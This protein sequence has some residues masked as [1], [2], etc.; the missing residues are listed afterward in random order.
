MYDNIIII[1]FR[2]RDEHLKYFIE[3]TVPLIKTHLPNSKVVVVEQNEGKLFNRGAILN[4]GFKEYKDKTKY[5][6]THDIDMNPTPEIVKSVYVREN[7]NVLRIKSPHDT[8]L[9]GISKI[10]H[11]TIFDV[12]GFPNY[13]WGWGIEDRA[14]YF[15]CRIKNI[16]ISNQQQKFKIMPHTSNARTYTGINKKYSDM[17]RE[18]YID[19]LDDKQRDEL[20][21]QSGINN[22]KYT[23]IERKMIDDIVELIKVSI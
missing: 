20:I 8:S 7:I 1:P 18:K 4:V 9:G 19:K 14:L 22:L 13:I 10:S 16:N 15:R 6:F 5:F 17:W 21:T 3:N 2:N 11:D 12:N 23:I